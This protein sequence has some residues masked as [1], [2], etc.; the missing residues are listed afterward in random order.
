MDE[1]ALYIIGDLHVSG[2]IIATGNMDSDR[3]KEALAIIQQQQQ[4]IDKLKEMM[5][6]VYYA[7]GMPGYL[8]AQESFNVQASKLEK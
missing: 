1:N 5:S 7:P 2:K 8:L 6:H 3:L 4:E